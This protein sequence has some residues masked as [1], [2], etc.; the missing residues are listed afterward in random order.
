MYNPLR[1]GMKVHHSAVLKELFLLS[2]SHDRRNVM[3]HQLLV[4]FIYLQNF[5]YTLYF[6]TYLLLRFPTLPQTHLLLQE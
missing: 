1:R 5:V 4:L 6:L 3:H 2:D